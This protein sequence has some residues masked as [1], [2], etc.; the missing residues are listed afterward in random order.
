MPLLDGRGGGGRRPNGIHYLESFTQYTTGYETNESTLEK[1]K[2]WEGC[3]VLVYFC[4][5][6]FALASGVSFRIHWYGIK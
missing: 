6:F 3:L 5:L 4:L 2:V 1:E